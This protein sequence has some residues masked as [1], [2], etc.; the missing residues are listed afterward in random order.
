MIR[1]KE[2]IGLLTS[3]L[4]VTQLSGQ[5]NDSLAVTTD[6]ALIEVE[7]LQDD[8]VLKTIDQANADFYAKTFL[9]EMTID[10]EI[11]STIIEIKLD[12]EIIAERIEKLN[13]MSPFELTHN[14]YVQAFISLYLIKKQEVT[15]KV[16]GLAPYYEPIFEEE[17]ARNNIPMELKYLP[18]VESALNPREREAVQEPWDCGNLCTEP[19]KCMD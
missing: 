16:L 2:L 14:R 15:R 1:I 18:I 13:K 12:E 8:E 19:G 11:D 9:S 6:S 3:T 17:L 10:G 7:W 5:K 4:L